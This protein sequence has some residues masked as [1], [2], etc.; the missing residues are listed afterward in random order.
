[1]GKLAVREILKQI[2]RLPK[3]D[4]EL[5]ETELAQRAEL[6]WR[7]EAAAARKV[8]RRRGINQAAIDQAVAQVRY[9][10][11]RGRR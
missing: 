2:D 3:T 9:A 5:L 7:R 8:A 6:E 1:M 4:Q 10:A 11:R